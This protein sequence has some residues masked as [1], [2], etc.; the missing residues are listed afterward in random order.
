ML[1]SQLL[2]LDEPTNHLD[3]EAILWL[4]KWL[5]DFDGL[6]VMVAHDRFFLDSVATDILHLRCRAPPLF[7]N[8]SSFGESPR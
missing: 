8:Y 6:L 5:L 4:E 3:V 2:V 1:P 7:G